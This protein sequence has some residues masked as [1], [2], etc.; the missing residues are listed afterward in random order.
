MTR[1]IVVAGCLLAGALYLAYGQAGSPPEALRSAPLR[2]EQDDQSQ[3][4]KIYR[5]NEKEPILTENARQ[6]ARPYLH[7][8]VAPDGNG[9]ITEYRPAH[10][11]HQTGI[12]W[13]FKL[14][15]GREFFMQ[16]QADH[17]RKVSAKVIRP[18]GLQVKW[19]TVYDLLDESGTPSLTE[20]QNWSMEAGGG[21]YVLD[22]EWRGLAKTDITI[23]KMYVGGLFVR[24]PWRP[25]DRAQ[26]VNS[27]G[28]RDSA[29]E[30][31]PADWFDVGIQIPGRSNLAHIAVFDSPGNSGFPTPWRIDNQ[32]GFGPN[33]EATVW[34]LNKGKEKVFRYRLIAYC[35]D[36][37]PAEMMGAWK[38]FAG[39]S[40]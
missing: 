12:Y 33:T 38:Q 39:G 27:A 30:Q 10:H 16:W 7:P 34:K 22:L 4:I 20:T 8:I 5:T 1:Q 40:H 2:A 18:K 29:A 21:K 25:E 11:L 32:F 23:G 28:L 26:A 19:Q 15:N 6:D 35:G 9:V 17:Y 37:D 36:L 3:T 31:Q 24:I 14:V 13:G